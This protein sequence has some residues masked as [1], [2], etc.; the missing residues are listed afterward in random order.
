M[1][2]RRSLSLCFGSLS[3]IG[4]LMATITN[5]TVRL[6]EAG[7][8]L[9]SDCFGNNAAIE[10]PRCLSYPVLLVALPNQRGSSNTNPGICRHCASRVYITDDVAQDQLEA[11]TVALVEE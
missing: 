7:Q 5:A 10:C 6:E 11:V 3:L 4:R 2:N 8:M 9:R 1:T